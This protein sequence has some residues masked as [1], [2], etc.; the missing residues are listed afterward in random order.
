M[1]RNGSGQYTLPAGNPVVT[2]TLI[3]S[4]G[5]ANPTLSDIAAALTN[6]IAAD[7]QTTPTANLPMG[8]FRHTGASAGVASGDYTTIGQLRGSGT[9]QGVALVG[10]PDGNTMAGLLSLGLNR[11]VD[12]IASLRSLS[13]LIYQRAFV[14]G[15]YAAHD[16]GGGAYQ[17]DT[18]DTTSTDNGGTIIVA[19]DGGRWKLQHTGS[20]SA[21]QFGAKGDN[22]TD[23][24]TALQAWL[25]CGLGSWFLPEGKF[26]HTGLTIPQIVGFTLFGVGTASVFVQ[27]GGAIGFP[28]MATNCFNSG[29]TIRDLAFDGTAGTENTLDTTYC[30]KLDLL[31]LD[32]NNVPVNFCSLKLDGNP[33]SSTYA[34]D[35]RV[36]NIR[37]YSVT[38][39]NAGI[40]LGAFHSDSSIDGFQMDGQFQVNYC[41][42]AQAGAQTT[43]VSNSHPYNAK[44]NV[45]RLQGGNT[46]FRWNDVTFDNALQDTFYMLNTVNNQFTHCFFQSTNPGKHAIVFDNSYNNN[47][48]NI[49]FEAPFGTAAAAF[50]EVNGS[51]GNK[52]SL[53]QL[54]DPSHWTAIANYA[55]FGSFVTGCQFYAPYNTIYPLSGTAQA[56]QVQ[57]TGRDFG[58]NGG[59]S[60]AYGN[61]AWCVALGGYVL[62]ATV[63]VDS[64]PASGQTYTFNL[65]KNGSSI[66]GVIINNGS[67]GSTFAPGPQNPVNVGDQLAIQ[68]IFSPTSGSA[69]PRY[70]VVMAG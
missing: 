18:A 48:T 46:H 6:S 13:K 68:S 26:C 60:G 65:R 40:A 51:S 21:R 59:S 47:L 27:K 30:Q 32:Y 3:S 45:V 36:K 11:V 1:P 34:H 49:K 10:T 33:T 24:T 12:S 56:P 64:T 50:Q 5:W 62:M 54:D 38:A 37:I 22:S 17:L 39:G 15:Y 69:T 14:T 7:G 25:N 70:A 4:S 52:M 19:S 67:F 44:I 55:G 57:N 20:V 23:D 31:N 42:L 53:F 35:V 9:S 63:F 41:L 8:G 58:A 43:Y 61:E 2:N 66:A 29:G 16:G 28:A